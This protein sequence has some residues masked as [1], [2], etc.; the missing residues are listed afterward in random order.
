MLIERICAKVVGGKATLE[1]RLLAEGKECGLSLEEMTALIGII[2][3]KLLNSSCF[4]DRLTSLWRYEFG[5]PYTIKEELLWGTHMW[6]PVKY[7]FAVLRCARDRLPEQQ[8]RRYFER[9][10]NPEKHE[11]T[12]VEFLP[13]LRLSEDTATNF[14]V[15]TGIGN[16]NADWCILSNTGR[17]VLLDVKNRSLDLIEEMKRIRAREDDPD[18][19]APAPTH[20]VTRLFR[21][22]EE[23]YAPSNPALQLQG[24]WIATNLQQEEKELT[25]AFDR[26]DQSKVH[27]VILGGWER[28]I[29]PLTRRDEDCQFLIDLFHEEVSNRY[30]FSRPHS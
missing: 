30:H 20:D 11:E 22:I 14:E 28:G 9:L 2:P 25:V 7:L 5:V 4:H 24:A 16:R 27:F 6:I 21:S 15:P 18:G 1:N 17:P 19:T 23:K 12:L 13:V 29:K 26:L 8:R 10:A 3:I